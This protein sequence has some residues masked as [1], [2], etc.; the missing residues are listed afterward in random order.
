[1]LW[2]LRSSERGLKY[3]MGRYVS[4]YRRSLRSSERGLK[5]TT[6]AKIFD[7]L[8]VAPFVGAWIEMAT[9]RK[10][11]CDK[12]VAPFVGAWIEISAKR[13]WVGY[14]RCRSV[15]RSVD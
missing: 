1:M 13:L 14:N 4:V 7:E 11:R 8:K 9:G 6:Y 12:A 5:S 3:V 10:C 15:R 2:S